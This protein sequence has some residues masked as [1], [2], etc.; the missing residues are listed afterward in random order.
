MRIRIDRL[1]LCIAGFVCA[2]I[3]SEIAIRMMHI[4]H[5]LDNEWLLYSQDKKISSRYIF[6]KDFS[7]PD[8]ATD[9]AKIFV[10]GDS[11]SEKGLWQRL[12]ID[13]YPE[14]LAPMVLPAR[15]YNFGIGAV[16]PDQ[17]FRYFIDNLLP[18]KPTAVIWQLYANDVM[19]NV[20]QPV[21]TIDKE[22]KLASLSGQSNWMYR[23]QLLYNVLPFPS[24]LMHSHLLKEVLY[25]FELTKYKDV[26]TQY[27]QQPQRWGLE[28]M[29]LEI[30]TMNALSRKYG[31][32]IFYVLIPPQATYLRVRDYY[33]L[34]PGAADAIAYDAAINTLLSYQPQYVHIRF[35]Q[36]EEA[37]ASPM[38]D[39]QIL[40][41]IYLHQ[42]DS[43]AFGDKHLS[44]LG[45]KIVAKQIFDTIAPFITSLK[46]TG[47]EE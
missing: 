44:Q 11:F 16:G 7:V 27:K 47:G 8:A 15:V 17:E 39:E 12:G 46:Y 4:R 29:K 45:Q 35:D 26:P 14:V 31:F 20:M 10:I 34:P 19:D 9:R 30:E 36:Q 1:F 37:G 18:L 3:F 25:A 22:G 24:V 13:S 41:D 2:L 42:E 28:K 5:T 23:R 38:S 6:E 43:N 21:Y 32:Q 33:A 40:N